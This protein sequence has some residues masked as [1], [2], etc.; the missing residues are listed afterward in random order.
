[1]DDLD[2]S[3]ARALAQ[4]RDLAADTEHARAQV[5]AARAALREAGARLDGGWAGLLARAQALLDAAGAAERELAAVHPV[6]EEALGARQTTVDE[7]LESAPEEARLTRREFE[8]LAVRA[9]ALG[10]ELAAA[11]AAA[12]EAEAALQERL[13][14][15]R[16]EV[17]ETAA[18]IERE[19]QVDLTAE[20]KAFETEVERSIGRLQSALDDCLSAV[21]QSGGEMFQQLVRTEDDLRAALD[22]AGSGAGGAAERAQED[23]ARGHEDALARLEQEGQDLTDALSALESWLG[24]GQ[25]ELE[26]DQEACEQAFRDTGQSLRDARQAL[27]EVEEMLARFSFVR[28]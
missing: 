7:L 6:L 12:E 18:E 20:L 15:V 2:T 13:A 21:E 1:M 5:A 10:P 4:A 17:E 14:Q 25:D 24:R 19:L 3:A 8:E 23:C 16:G 11:V 28:L 26:S 22:A 27:R 9:E